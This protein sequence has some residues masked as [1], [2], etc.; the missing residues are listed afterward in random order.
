[1]VAVFTSIDCGSDSDSYT[2]E[3]SIKWIGDGGLISEGEPRAVRADSEHRSLRTLRVFTGP[4]KKYCYAIPAEKGGKVL[5]RTTFY[6]GNYDGKSSPPSF[7]L[8]ADGN[9]WERRV[10]FASVDQVVPYEAIYVPKGDYVSVCVART[11]P[12]QFPIISA[13]EVRSVGS[14]MYGRAN[15]THALLTKLR[16]PFGANKDIR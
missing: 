11:N 7:A 3:N 8:F 12:G 6:Y 13:I 2:D 9:V 5:L 4:R 15:S 1:M 16:I 14:D 10:S